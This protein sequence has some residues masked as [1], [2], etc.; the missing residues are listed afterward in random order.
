MATFKSAF[1]AARKSGKKEFTWNGK[2]YNTK[3]KG[4]STKPKAKALKKPV[5]VKT[6]TLGKA[7]TATIRKIAEK[8]ID[9][10]ATKRAP[11]K[12]LRPKARAAAKTP[13]PA[14]KPA[15]VTTNPKPLNDNKP[16]K[17]ST[18]QKPT[19]KKKYNIKDKTR[20]GKILSVRKTTAPKKSL[21]PKARS[22]ASKS[23]G[24]FRSAFA[25]AR[26]AG[27]TQFTWKGK[28]YNT[29]MK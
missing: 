20:S 17:G 18:V 10:K 7:K 11:T 9:G 29:K 26:K 12:S 16:Q 1:G 13:T 6:K 5:P 24:T 21:K 19:P 3:V 4:E 23:S 8:A 25:S 27:K 15:P 14:K 22:T 2:R 28:K